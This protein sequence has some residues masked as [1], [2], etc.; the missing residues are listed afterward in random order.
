M[1]GRKMSAGK[2]DAGKTEIGMSYKSNFRT[3]NI[4]GKTP[5][6][7]RHEVQAVRFG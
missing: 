7:K 3:V 2:M 4:W 1:D 6:E 5:K